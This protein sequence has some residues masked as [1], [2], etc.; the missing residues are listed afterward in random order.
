M[1]V[2]ISKIFGFPCLL[3]EILKRYYS[4]RPTLKLNESNYRF[5]VGFAQ[6]LKGPSPRTYAS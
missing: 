3:H 5:D 2:K 1:H 6:S 4:K